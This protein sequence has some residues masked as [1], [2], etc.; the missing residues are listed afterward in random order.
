LATAQTKEERI[1]TKRCGFAKYF[2]QF[3]E[4]FYF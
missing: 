4:Y 3:F 1:L 2:A